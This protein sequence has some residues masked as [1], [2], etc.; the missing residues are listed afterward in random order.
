LRTFSLQ[1]KVMHQL[2]SNDIFSKM[3]I[4]WL[5]HSSHS[6]HWWFQEQ[7]QI[8]VLHSREKV[9][10]N[11]CHD[12]DKVLV[13]VHTIACTSTHAHSNTPDLFLQCSSFYDFYWTCRVSSICIS[14][15]ISLQS[16]ILALMNQLDTCTNLDVAEH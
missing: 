12:F 7:H 4:L 9:Q 13:W 1:Y 8:A 14:S 5:I 6:L 11:Q 16:L 10:P 15:T 3:P 2:S